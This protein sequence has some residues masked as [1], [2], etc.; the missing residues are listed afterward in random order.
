MIIIVVNLSKTSLLYF[1]YFLVMFQVQMRSII[2]TIHARITLDCSSKLS[3]HLLVYLLEVV[4]HVKY[5]TY[6]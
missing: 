5:A 3:L 1:D 4:H 2:L 6:I